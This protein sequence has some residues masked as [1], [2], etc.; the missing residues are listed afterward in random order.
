MGRVGYYDSG[1]PTGKWCWD[2]IT[3]PLL[4]VGMKET[5]GFGFPLREIVSLNDFI[6]SLMSNYLNLPSL[7]YIVHH[8]KTK[9]INFQ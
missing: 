2:W 1:Q 7:Q 6:L 5:L 4:C 3:H 8:E 9:Y